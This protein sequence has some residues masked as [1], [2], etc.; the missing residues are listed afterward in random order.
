LSEPGKLTG[1]PAGVARRMAGIEPFHVMSILAR[2]RALEAEGR[3]IVHLEIGEP[4]FPTPPPIIAA[5]QQALAEGRTKYT[6]AIGLPALREAIAS[7]YA[8]RYGVTVAAERIVVT[9]GASGALQL[10]LGT[11]VNP[12]EQVLLP[13]PAYPCNR[14][15]VRLFNGAPVSL[16]TR[17]TAGFQ[18]SC[19]QVAEAWGAQTR[20]LMLAT[21]ANPTGI[22]LSQDE[23]AAHYANVRRLGGALIVDEIYQGLEYGHASVTALA[24]GEQDLF[25]VNSFS[26][27][28][29]MTGWRL[30]WV[31]APTEWVPVLDRLAQNIFLAAPTISQYAALAAF[32]PDSLA[33]MEQQRQVLEARRDL[34][35]AAVRE[36]GFKVAG[37]PQ[38]AFYLYADCS[39]LAD[40]SATLAADLLERAGVAI[41]PGLD[42]G[43]A[44]AGAYVRFAYSTDEARLAEGVARIRAY[45]KAGG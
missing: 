22:C 17:G 38:G 7:Y 44:E 20:A 42:F 43:S 19:Q 15:M 26:K 32:S 10:V 13:D 21:P 1:D 3:D 25:V 4:D 40:D 45:L 16:P 30:G 27:Y 33:I 23:L 39:D 11:L 35:L 2:A 18:L 34:L 5:G 41:T 28:F 31:V 24:L 9:P 8:Q 12:G 6:Q 37:E 36:L 29:G 14:H